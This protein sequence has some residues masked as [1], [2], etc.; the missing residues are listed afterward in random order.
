M[1]ILITS[2]GTVVKIDDVRHIGNMSSGTFG[3][4]IATEALKLNHKVLFLH[5]K[6]SKTPFYID[7]DLDNKEINYKQQISKLNKI[8]SLHKSYNKNYVGIPFNDFNSY[9]ETLKMSCGLSEQYFN[10]NKYKRDK[11]EKDILQADVI[12]LAAAV[13]D[14]GV[15]KIEGK[16]RSKDQM[17]IELKPLPKIIS[18][19]KNWAP[20]SK[21]VGFKLL[22]NSTEEE[23]ISAAKKSI[24]YNGCD[25]V[26]ANDLRDIKNNAHR[27]MLVK[28]DTVITYNATNDPNYLA[29]MLIKEI[30]KL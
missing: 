20:H 17:S 4:K 24:V 10:L 26:V 1:N 6:N 5:A 28:K 3:S 16:L 27:I 15:D 2:G 13:S 12:L 30:E 23:L 8:N 11:Y 19:V 18:N 22:V 7:I 21:L 29:K 9:Q 25:L 14:Y